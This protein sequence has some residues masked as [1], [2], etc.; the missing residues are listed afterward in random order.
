MIDNGDIGI[1]SDVNV[2]ADFVIQVV[3]DIM[4]DFAIDIVD[5]IVNFAIDIIVNNVVLAIV[6]IISSRSSE[7]FFWL[8]KGEKFFDVFAKAFAEKEVDEGVVSS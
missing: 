3:V 8:F 4:V 2:V 5:I 1:D 6:Q 7:L